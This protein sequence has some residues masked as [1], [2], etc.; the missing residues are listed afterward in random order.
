MPAELENP[1]LRSGLVFAG[2]NRTGAARK[3]VEDGILTALEVSGLTVGYA[4]GCAQRPV[5]RV[6]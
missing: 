2:A 4:S 6:S 3:G 1:L 5:R